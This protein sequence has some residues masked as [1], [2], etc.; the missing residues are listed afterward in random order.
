M[1]RNNLQAARGKHLI[2]LMVLLSLVIPIWAQTQGKI[3]NKSRGLLIAATSFRSLTATPQPSAKPDGNGYTKHQLGYYLDPNQVSFV[4]PG[5]KFT[6]QDVTIG[7]DN[8]IRV[9]YLITD[10]NGLPLDR[11]G[12]VTPGAVSTS[13]VGGLHPPRAISVC[14]L[15]DS[16]SDQPDHRCV[17]GPGRCRHG[18]HA[19]ASRGRNLHVHFWTGRFRPIR[20]DNDPHRRDVWPN[21]NLTEFDLGTQ[22]S[23][24]VY[25][26]VP[27]GAPVTHVRDVV[28][29]ETCNKC[30]DP[31]ALH[32]GSRRS[33]RLRHLPHTADNGSRHWKHPRFKVMVHEDSCGPNLQ[34][35]SW[36]ALRNHREPAMRQ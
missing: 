1:I 21:R 16:N 30:H 12:V 3:G 28:R 5:L 9:T 4:R 15:H 22:V 6:I 19:T 33:R 2:L 36:Q 8:K 25:H 17:C 34:C 29:T 11:L 32:G 7:A 23:N 35:L 27:S 26:W 14:G 18:W 24:V 10:N 13:F 20:P 31:L